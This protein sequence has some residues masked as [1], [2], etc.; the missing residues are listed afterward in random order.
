MEVLVDK[1]KTKAIGECWYWISDKLLCYPPPL[2]TSTS[3]SAPKK[4]E[5]KKEGGGEKRP[6]E[7]QYT[8]DE[9]DPG[10][11]ENQASGQSG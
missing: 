1:G 6:I 2:C 8:E 4:H 7:F 9:A 11:R 3:V 10:M 5:L